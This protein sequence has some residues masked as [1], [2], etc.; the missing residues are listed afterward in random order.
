MTEQNQE[1]SDLTEILAKYAEEYGKD[2]YIDELR[3]REVLLKI[4]GIKGKWITYKA[5]NTAKLIKLKKQKQQLLDEGIDMIKQKRDEEG[6]PVSRRGAE[7]I[8][9]N[10]KKYRE[11]NERVESLTALV[12]YFNDS[13][14]AILDINWDIKNLIDN[15]KM[16]EM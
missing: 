14:E 11:L 8:L 10:T 15:N 9:K 13:V 2:T 4:A 3:L 12:T 7:M 6:N 16:E 1:P 5:M